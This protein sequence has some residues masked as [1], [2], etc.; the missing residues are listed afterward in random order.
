MSKHP[1]KTQELLI[2]YWEWDEK[3]PHAGG[4]FWAAHAIRD[5]GRLEDWWKLGLRPLG[6]SRVVVTEG[7][8]LELLPP[9]IREGA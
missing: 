8:G 9:K 1:P 4:K 5:D 3:S 6:A 2:V 7:I